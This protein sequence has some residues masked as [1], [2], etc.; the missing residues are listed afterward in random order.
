MLDNINLMLAEPPPLSVLRADGRVVEDRGIL[1]VPHYARGTLT[2]YETSLNNLKLF[3]YPER[4]VLKNSLHKYAHRGGNSDDFYCSEIPTVIQNI[5][6]VTQVDW[7]RAEVKALEI[8]V[9]VEC[10]PVKAVSVLK[11]YKAKPFQP[12]TYKGKAY[13]SRCDFQRYSLKGYNKSFVAQKVDGLAISKPLFRWESQIHSMQFFAR[14]LPLPIKV[15]DLFKLQNLKIMAQSSVEQLK[16]SI[17]LEGVNLSG[18]TAEEKKVLGVM[19]NDDLRENFR[20]NHR[21]AFKKYRPI[22]KRIMEAQKNNFVS[23]LETSI[24]QKF[25][26]LLTN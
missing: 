2:R 7:S 26:E 20:L 8:G 11:S 17:K 14:S 12:M 3:A 23:D 24:K 21:E 15:S 22:F 13:G 16:N 9:N 25:M 4:M 10:D 19:M 6:E 18:L 1:W 5:S